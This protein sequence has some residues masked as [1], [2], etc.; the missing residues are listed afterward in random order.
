SPGRVLPGYGEDHCDREGV[1]PDVPVAVGD[2]FDLAVAPVFDLVQAVLPGLAV[3]APLGDLPLIAPGLGRAEQG[4]L[5]RLAVGQC[6]AQGR[7]EPL[8]AGHDPAP[9]VVLAGGGGGA[10]RGEAAVGAGGAPAR[11]RVP[12]A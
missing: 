6:L 9:L 7:G 2:P 12:G 11:R 1:W 8:G 10:P 3:P 4:S 5:L